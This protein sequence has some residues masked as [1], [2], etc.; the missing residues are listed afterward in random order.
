MAICRLCSEFPGCSFCDITP[1]GWLFSDPA[2]FE[3]SRL[4][5]VNPTHSLVR[6]DRHRLDCSFG[7]LTRMKRIVFM[8]PQETHTIS[9]SL[10]QAWTGQGVSTLPTNQGLPG[11]R[12]HDNLPL[13]ILELGSGLSPSCNY[14]FTIQLG[15]NLAGSRKRGV[16]GR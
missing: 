15:P 13:H 12:D 8:C 5:L 1:L 7:A 2:T 4:L 6:P 10:L 16:T 14:S 9:H 11:G 3:S